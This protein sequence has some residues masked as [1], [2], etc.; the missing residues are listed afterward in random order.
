M[1]GGTKFDNCV[2]L[3][4][5]FPGPVRPLRRNGALSEVRIVLA[6]CV[7]KGI[8]EVGKLLAE[9]VNSRKVL[10]EF[11]SVPWIWTIHGPS[12]RLALGIDD[13]DVVDRVGPRRT[14]AF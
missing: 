2:R 6:V 8:V 9:V 11:T 3:G 5:M 7:L 1:D 13:V 10:L 12:S 14:T 4:G